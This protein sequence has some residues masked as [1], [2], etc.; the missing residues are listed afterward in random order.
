MMNTRL[1]SLQKSFLALIPVIALT[2][3]ISAVPGSDP[4]PAPKGKIHHTGYI[5]LKEPGNKEHQQRIIDA[6]HRFAAQIPEVK[7]LSVGKSVPKGS[8]LMDTTFDISL[9]M[10]FDD[11]AAMER[12]NKHP[13]HEKA[14]KEDFLPLSAKI[15]FYDFVSE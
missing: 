12:Y 9:T 8:P 13:V 4:G 3:L 7:G 5:W 11:Q 2:L 1:Q 14:A 15:L 10:H 6:A